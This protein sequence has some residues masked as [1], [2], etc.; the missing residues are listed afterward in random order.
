MKK[1]NNY[2]LANCQIFT[3]D[4]TNGIIKNGVIL[5]NN[6]DNKGI[7]YGIFGNI[8]EIDKIKIPKDHE[9]IDLSGKYIIPGLINAHA[10]LTGDGKPRNITK[11]DDKSLKRLLWIARRWI[12][13]K[14]IKRMMRK[15]VKNALNAGITT[16]RSLGDPYYYDIETR[17]A[18][19]VG[20]FVGPRL[21]VAGRSLC[22]T[23][24]HGWMMSY[25]IDSPWDARKAVRK[26]VA[27]GVD[28]I[29]LIATGGV[30]DSKKIGEAGRPQ[31][32]IEEI[33]AA[34]DEAHRAG[35]KVAAHAE[36]TQGVKEALKGGVDTI[37]HGAELDRES[38]KLFK[39]NPNS[40]KGYSVL[41]PTLSAPL[42]ICAWGEQ[43]LQ[44]TSVQR[45]N[46]FLLKDEM[47]SGFKQALN[48]NIKIGVGTDATVTFVTHYDFWK[49]LLYMSEH[50]KI[51]P[52][53]VIYLATKCNSEI[54]D[55]ETQTGTIENGKSADFIV[56]EENPLKDLNVLAFPF[57][58]GIRG[59]LIE[60][61]KIKKIKKIEKLKKIKQF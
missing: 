41:I 59:N 13:R 3:G 18:I 55:I 9:I 28:V 11:K 23:G 21:L 30:M 31:M 61:P 60:R 24:G 12:G 36:S 53:F 56:F 44:M 16:I 20:N 40:L 48:E 54:L 27:A 5:I 37:E 49:E 45:E 35:L 4:L 32:T 10:H 50:G 15:N 43:E 29:K 2:A 57:M 19:G 47:I 33:S 58:V 1:S 38:I 46:A 52:K 42:A 34:C 14:I 17:D 25:V 39:N 22:I 6:R 51:D 8:G 26:N 7:N